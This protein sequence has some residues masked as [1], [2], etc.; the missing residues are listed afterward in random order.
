MRTFIAITFAASIVIYATLADAAK[1]AAQDALY[2]RQT[3]TI[4]APAPTQAPGTDT[5]RTLPELTP[6]METPTGWDTAQT[7]T[8]TPMPEPIADDNAGEHGELLGTLQIY[9]YNPYDPRQVGKR[10]ADGITASGEPAEPGKTCAMSGE[11]P[12]GAV[13]YVEGL[14]AYRVNDRGVGE[15]IV[16]IA[17]ATDAECYAITRKARVWLMEEK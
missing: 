4:Y 5:R 12:F 10:A 15:G 13:V 3:V 11:V 6:A 17:A 16:D 7:A 14:G 1:Q 8:P 2:T 9:G